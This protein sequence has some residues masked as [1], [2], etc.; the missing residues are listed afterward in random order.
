[1]SPLRLSPSFKAH[2]T[3]QWIVLIV[4]GGLAGFILHKAGLPAALLLGPMLVAIAMGTLGARIQ[5]P[6][7]LF[8]SGQGVV[9]LLVAKSVTLSVLLA[10]AKDWYLMALVTLLT[11]GL[12]FGVG[13]ILACASKIPPDAAAWGTG[14]G[15]ASAMIAMA[16][17]QGADSR[18]VASMQYIRVVCV[19]MLGAW[20]SHMLVAPGAMHELTQMEVGSNWLGL[21]ATLALAFM[22]ALSGNLIP[23]GALITPIILG[24]ALQLSGYM[25]ITLN[26]TIMTLAYGAIGGYIGLRFTRATI[27]QVARL[28][29]VILTANIVLIVLCGLLAWPLSGVFQKDFLSMFLATSPGGLDS[30]AII[31]VET[32][33]DASFV[34][35]LQTLR[36]LGVVLCGAVCSNLVI[37]LSTKFSGH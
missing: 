7:I 22:G 2:K 26:D 15:A 33:S 21:L 17:E 19:V 13:L 8:R 12:S 35:A 27:I 16:E 14:P 31:A 34:V 23:A 37:K 5:V 28:V 24:T 20:V 36:L 30:M 29:P 9:G 1:M 18:I 32:G 4:A 25:E 11:I 10:L 3:L 6:R